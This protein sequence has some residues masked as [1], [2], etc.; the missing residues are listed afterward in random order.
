[1]IA[2]WTRRATPPVR[3]R[4]AVTKGPG[5]RQ[6]GLAMI[7]KLMEAAEGRWRKLTGAQMVGLVR[8]GAEF[9]NGQMVE[10]TEEKVAA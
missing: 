3:P 10:G 4:T 7:F 6:T 1:M 8:A 5:S 9:K 2:E